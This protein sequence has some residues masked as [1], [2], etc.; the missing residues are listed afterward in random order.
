[1]SMADEMHDFGCKSQTRGFPEQ[2]NCSVRLRRENTALADRV[3]ALEAE[4]DAIQ[5]WREHF[6]RLSEERHAEVKRLQAAIPTD[7]EWSDI[8]AIYVAVTVL[9]PKE[10]RALWRVLNVLRALAE[11][12]P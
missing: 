10:S 3:E 2:C 9:L 5:G 11:K 7:A 12:K 8:E 4:R 1:M 6:E